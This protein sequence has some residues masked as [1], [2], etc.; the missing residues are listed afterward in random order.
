MRKVSL[1]IDGDLAKNVQTVRLLLTGDG[2]LSGERT[3]TAQDNNL[4]PLE[5]RLVAGTNERLVAG[6]NNCQ[7]GLEERLV[8]G[9]NN[10]QPGF[11]LWGMPSTGQPQLTQIL[12]CKHQLTQI[13]EWRLATAYM[14]PR[15]WKHAAL[16][17]VVNG[18]MH[19]LPL[20]SS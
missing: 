18:S 20:N 11:F 12:G 7:P 8:A 19:R 9:T 14:P 10:C 17:V 15:R 13:L 6:T 3:F 4:S 16:L 1:R 2:E 5:E